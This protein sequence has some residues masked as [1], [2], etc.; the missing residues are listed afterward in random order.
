M[1][2]FFRELSLPSSSS[3]P[4]TSVINFLSL[5]I[6]FGQ[7]L[8]D[9]N[10]PHVFQLH[11]N[12]CRA[13]HAA[14][15]GSI[16]RYHYSMP[17]IPLGALE[18]WVLRRKSADSAFFWSSWPVIVT[19]HCFSLPICSPL[20]LL[21]RTTYSVQWE[22]NQVVLLTTC[23]TS[24]EVGK[25][26]KYLHGEEHFFYWLCSKAKM[27]RGDN[28]FF[29]GNRDTFWAEEQPRWPGLL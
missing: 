4:L 25:P 1:I 5:S 3:A 29:I 27:T 2:H 13:G 23:R 21:W 12:V 20:L 28:I 6:N 26:T 16:W 7:V 14:V 17:A 24:A 11:P 9:E 8:P 18:A 22:E 15:A 19:D 10:G